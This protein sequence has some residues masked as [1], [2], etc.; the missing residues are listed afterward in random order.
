MNYNGTYEIGTGNRIYSINNITTGINKVET[1]TE[2]ANAP[3]YNLS[4]QRVNDSYKGIVIKNGK[5]YINR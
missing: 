1:D 3:V 4:G 2:D 5:K